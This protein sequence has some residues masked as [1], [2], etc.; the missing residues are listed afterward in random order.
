MRPSLPPHWLRHSALLPWLPR[1]TPHSLVPRRIATTSAA[2]PAPVDLPRL[3]LTP[4]SP[5][6]DSLPSFLEYAHRIQLLHNT[7][8]Y[9]GTHYEYMTSLALMRFGMSLTRVGRRADAGIDLIGHWVMTPLREPMPVIIQCKARVSTIGPCHVRELEGT[10][11]ATPPHWRNKDVL[12]ILITNNRATKGMLESLGRSAHPLAFAMVTK[13]GIIQQFIW[14]RAASDHGLEGLGVT[15]RHTPTPPASPDSLPRPRGRPRKHQVQNIIT[16]VQL[17]WMGSPIF[18]QRQVPSRVALELANAD[19]PPNTGKT[20]PRLPHD[21]IPSPHGGCVVSPREALDATKPRRGRPKG[22]KNKILNQ[23]RPAAE[24]NY[25]RKLF[26]NMMV[27]TLQ[28]S[29]PNKPIDA[30]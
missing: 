17:T 9:V 18:P 5:F 30:G 23:P 29:I 13:A 22:S 3:A 28:R 16:D 20:R 14:N 26:R 6:H 4:G 27:R 7:T 1:A 10:L 12:G 19:V 8:V 21:S 11:Q 2:N 24:E 15:L 25:K